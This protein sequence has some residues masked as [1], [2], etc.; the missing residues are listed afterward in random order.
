MCVWVSVYC[1]R[2]SSGCLF[3][4][5]I[6]HC[7]LFELVSNGS[8][9]QRTRFTHPLHKYTTNIIGVT[10]GDRFGLARVSQGHTIM[11]E[12]TLY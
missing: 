12:V 10:E 5:E 3:I 9:N 7:A 2:E 4:S 8:D 1:C 6:L 11:S